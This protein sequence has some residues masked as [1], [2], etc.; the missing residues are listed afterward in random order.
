MH[1]KGSGTDA[2]ALR[3]DM[4]AGIGCPVFEGEMKWTA[5]LKHPL[6]WFSL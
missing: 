6:G 2:M 1:S 3:G 5:E 4:E